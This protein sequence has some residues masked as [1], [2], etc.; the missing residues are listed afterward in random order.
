MIQKEQVKKRPPNWLPVFSSIVRFEKEEIVVSTE[1]LFPKGEIVKFFD[2]QD[3]GFIKDQHGKDVYF[4]L[5]ELD[6]VGPKNSKEHV[7][8]GAKIGYDLSWTSHGQHVRRM[9]IY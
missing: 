9:K 1:D 3:Y 5:N 6:F 8:V 2:K 7:K 4:H